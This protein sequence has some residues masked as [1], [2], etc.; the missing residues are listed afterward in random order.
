ME[1]DEVS[2]SAKPVCVLEKVFGKKISSSLEARPR[3]DAL[4][5]ESKE[6]KPVC[7]LE[8]GFG[9][10]ASALLSSVGLGCICFL[11]SGCTC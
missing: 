5:V 10:I 2:P 6:L 8:N 7:V 9:S 11:N 4:E 3:L 1:E